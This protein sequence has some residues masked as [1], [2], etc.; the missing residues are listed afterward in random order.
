MELSK[1]FTL[2][3]LTHSDTAVRKG[4]QNTPTPEQVENL[5]M[6]ASVLEQIREL[7]GKPVKVSSGFRCPELNRAIGGSKSSAHMQGLAADIYVDGMPAKQLAIAIRDAGIVMDQLI[8]EGSWVHIGLS[9]ELPRKQVLTALFLKA[10]TRYL[11]GI[12]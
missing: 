12:K 9:A 5:K 2:Q 6:V 4:I 1:H 8:Y 10:G 7:V 3:E 11:E